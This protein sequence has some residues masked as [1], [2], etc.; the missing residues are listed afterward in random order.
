[1]SKKQNTEPTCPHCSVRIS[2]H[3]ASRCLAVWIAV[4]VMEWEKTEQR[5]VVLK[6][7]L[8]YPQ[9]WYKT[10]DGR[11]VN[12]TNIPDYPSSTIAALEVIERLKEK[13]FWFSLVYKSAIF[14]DDLNKAGWSA[15][16]RCVRGGTRG[17]HFGVSTRLSL[18]ICRAAIKGSQ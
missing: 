13:D 9:E 11:I 6:D 14:S 10:P 15:Q 4:D 12:I 8:D 17:D 2:E 18:A 5:P 7:W 1:M 3:P 16:F